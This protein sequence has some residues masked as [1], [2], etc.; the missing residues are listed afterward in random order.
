MPCLARDYLVEDLR[1]HLRKAAVTR[2]VL[3]AVIDHLSKPLESWASLIERAA[4]YPNVY[5][6]LSGLVTEADHASWARAALA[7]PM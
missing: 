1:P 2:T 6:K 4:E 5:C 3:C 7:P